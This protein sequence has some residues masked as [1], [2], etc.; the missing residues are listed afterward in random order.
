MGGVPLPEG[1][2][3]VNPYIVVDDAERLIDFLVRVFAGVE[4][5]RSLRLDGRID[6]GDV[7]I[8]DSLVMLSEASEQYP[9]R[10]CVHFVYVPDVDV[11]YRA[12]LAAGA[13]GAVPVI[14]ARRKEIF[15]LS[16]G[17]VR[18]LAPASLEVDPGRTY[19]GDGAVR[20]RATIEAA[21]GV[22]PADESELHLPR[23]RFHA[24]LADRGGPAEQV[25][26][27]YVRAPDAEKALA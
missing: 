5:G 24:Q 12:A 16:S 7:R 21:G 3:S 13:P 17:H 1:Y 4:Q 27:V 11:T 9:A 22:V 6:H 18:C 10:P 20:Y 23:A 15:V 2:H 14:D 25:E 26:P 19:V 8:G